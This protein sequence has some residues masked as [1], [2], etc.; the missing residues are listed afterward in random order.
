M[1]MISFL[2]KTFASTFFASIIIFFYYTVFSFHTET[3]SG[4]FLYFILLGISYIIYKVITYYKEKNT[5]TFT[6]FHLFLFFSL[7]LFF[8]CLSFFQ[9]SWE[10]IW[11]GIILFS[12]ILFFLVLPVFL[13]FLFYAL[14]KKIL[15]YK[16]SFGEESW[17]FQLFLSFWLWFF[18]FL[19]TLSLFWFFGFYNL[20]V[21]LGLIII[22]FS[23]S[24]KVFV[25]AIKNF[26]NFPIEIQ[27]HKPNS[28]HFIERINPFLLSSEFLFIVLSSL[29]AVNFINVMRPF[30]IGWDDLG[31]YMNFPRL[32][33][34][35]GEI[36]PLGQMMSWQIFTGIWFLFGG[37]TQAF[38]LNSFAW[39]L[40][41]IFIFLF[42]FSF[43]KQT[44]EKKLFFNIPL[45]A[46]TIYISLPMVIFHLAKDMKLDQGLF[47]ISIIILFLVYYLF[48]FRESIKKND[49]I[50]FFIIG[51][52]LGFAFSIKVTSLL[53]I[54][55]IFWLLFF[56]FFGF[57]WFL[58]YLGLYF[59]LFTKF[60]FWKMMNVAY[61][62]SPEFVNLFSLITLI[63]WLWFF[64]YAL[65]KNKKIQLFFT[66]FAL[67]FSGII[68][69]LLPWIGHNIASIESW[70]ISISKIVNGEKKTY[71]PD[72]TQIHSQSYIDSIS[73]RSRI[74]STGTTQNEDFWRYFG[75]E[76]GINNY[77]KL[78]WNLTM[79]KNQ[80][81]E[82]TEISY[83]FL[84][85]LP[86]LLLF[87]PFRKRYFEFG[88]YF[89]ILAFILFFMMP[90]GVILLT[91]FL[92][93]FTLPFGYLI[94][95]W[96]FLT[97]LLFFI[98]G[99][100]FKKN[101]LLELFIFNLIFG[102]F[103]TFLW[104]IAA[105]W[106]VWYGIVMYMFLL[107]ALSFW[108]Y[109]MFLYDSTLK[110]KDITKRFY[111]SLIIFFLI[112]FYFFNSSL[113][114]LFNNLKSAWYTN[115]KVGNMTE[116]EAV[117]KLHS[118]YL[119]VLF[120]LNIARDKQQAFL[121]LIKNNLLAIVSKYEQVKIP[122][123]MILWISSIEESVH[124]MNNII[125][126]IPNSSFSS[127]I[128]EQLMRSL[129][130]QE[131][132]VYNT[133]LNPDKELKNKDFIYRVGTF[134]KYFIV[135]NNERLYE[136][137]LISKFFDYFYDKENIDMAFE[138][139][140]TLGMRYLLVDLNAA[141]IDQS[142]EGSLTKRYEALLDSFRSERVSLVSTDSICLQVALEDY[143]KSK[144]DEEAKEN[145][146][147]IAGV[148]FN[149]Q[150][151]SKQEKLQACFQ[152]VHEII[153][154]K[155]SS[156]S[157]Y[158]YLLWIADY[159]EKNKE[160]FQTSEDYVRFYSQYIRAWYK[161][162]FRID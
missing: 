78:P 30:P 102:A 46:T 161:A 82:Y 125:K 55:G 70:N 152:R 61:P 88:L 11:N 62:T 79:Q 5:L 89:Y 127:Q 153:N 106:V 39:V 4:Y 18:I 150:N 7:N 119:V 146:M 156:K 71:T 21:V 34:S 33:A 120:E 17:V 69:A 73:K 148:N 129:K 20:W 63:I 58:W 142:P 110:D 64:A 160:S 115:Y 135:N 32:I 65:R 40:V 137:S 42:L 92:S 162:L 54:S 67:L 48:Y 84:A 41:A 147:K 101:R 143:K 22:S 31:V 85:F 59:S 28:S 12:R 90:N 154:E 124:F 139:M 104:S 27:N 94:I 95:F 3:S 49:F 2:I 14:W 97:N 91:N 158:T 15:S 132:L 145:F 50:Y 76:K 130:G 74:T 105:F 36:F 53:L 111:A 134:M 29:I 141:T 157:D 118:D 133:V 140:K 108:L 138:R 1:P 77:I 52:L 149:A 112:V 24:F 107:I 131:M 45:L 151:A 126:E 56:F 51:I 86:I 155:L 38:Y 13:S 80:P 103:Y 81:W 16:K 19:T 144:K 128:K 121:T 23:F 136:D 116:K 114:H 87:L 122:E 109:Y 159:I 9:I 100:D 10:A 35:A 57:S 83:I 113:P 47:L 44:K 26:W 66:L 8:L 117:F 6:P 99:L 98:Y 37:S 75:Y 60:G 72:L 123:D 96:V 93:L 43:F 68:I 25:S